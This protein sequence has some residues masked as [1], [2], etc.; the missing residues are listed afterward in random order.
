MIKIKTPLEI[1][2]MQVANQIV[3]EALAE[4]TAYVKPDIETLELDALAEEICRRR[5]VKP[6]FKNYR[7][8][9]S[10]ICVSIN[11]EIV[12]GI[13][14]HR[15]INA[16]DLVSID[17]GVRYDGYFGDA[18]VTF[19]VGQ[20]S[21]T[22]EKLMKATEEA[23]YAGIAKVAIGNRLSDVSHA[24]Q[25]TVESYGFSVIRDFVGHGIGRSL[26]ED[27]QIPNYGSPG[28]GPVLQPGM[29]LAIE[30]MVSAGRWEISVMPDG[31]TAITKDGSLAAH[32]EHTVALT[33]K[34]VLI[35]SKL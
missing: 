8:Y 2:K 33:E 29:T 3:A 32:Y 7:G 22:A 31:W 12:H 19:A 20:I 23:L 17:F 34:G 14:S 4:I 26:H 30:P 6:A 1:S 24:V 15:R 16:G 35:L 5:K 28:H 11:D 13:P 10:S 27:P 25:S 9:P 21:D 18:A